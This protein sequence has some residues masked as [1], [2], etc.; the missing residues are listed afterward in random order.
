VPRK[1]TVSFAESVV[2]DLE[3]LQAWHVE[4]GAPE[5]GQRLVAE[6]FKRIEGLPDNPDMGR[7][8]L[9]FKQPFLRELIHSPFRIVYRREAQRIRIVRVW[10]SERL[11]KLPQESLSPKAR[12]G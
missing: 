12:K 1:I 8:V 9:E 4:Q 11:L 5:A 7:I 10:R 3:E 6:I 2:R